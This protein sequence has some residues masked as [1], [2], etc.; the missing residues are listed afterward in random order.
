MDWDLHA[1]ER[2][3]GDEIEAIVG[4][5]SRHPN[6]YA[7]LAVCRRALDSGLEAVDE[8]VIEQ[9]RAHLSQAPEDEL[10]AYYSIVT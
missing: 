10:D 9:L 8:R 6:S 5:V 1:A 7:S 2:S 3:R 4:F